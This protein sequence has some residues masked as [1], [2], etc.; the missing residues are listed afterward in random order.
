MMMAPCS[1]RILR[2]R[3]GSTRSWLL[4]HQHA[5]TWTPS[6]PAL[7]RPPQRNPRPGLCAWI[8]GFRPEYY[9]PQAR[10]SP[11]QS[12]RGPKLARAS[13]ALPSRYLAKA[14]LPGASS[15]TCLVSASSA[16]ADHAIIATRSL[17]RVLYGLCVIH[18]LPRFEGGVCGSDDEPNVGCLALR[19]LFFC[20]VQI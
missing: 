4:G 6:V 9:R 7:R 14:G 15:L 20:G 3:V 17:H 12:S 16:I 19:R 8:S 11:H 5:P 2:S 13:H 18:Q 10:Q 1:S